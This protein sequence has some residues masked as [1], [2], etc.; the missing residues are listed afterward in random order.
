MVSL[1]RGNV[2]YVNGEARPYH[3]KQV[4]VVREPNQEGGLEDVAAEAGEAE[5]QGEVEEVQ[6]DE[7]L[8]E[9]VEEDVVSRE[10]DS[11][12]SEPRIRLTR[13]E[14]FLQ[15]LSSLHRAGKR[16]IRPSTKARAAGGM[17]GGGGD[18]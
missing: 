15:S 8:L 7:N 4:K 5:I 12:A 18:R 1:V 17:G 9:N 10:G 16:L 14:A 13:E 6:T 2:V 11:R 3:A